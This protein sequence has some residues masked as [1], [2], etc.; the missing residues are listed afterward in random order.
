MS[1]RVLV[2]PEDPTNNGYILKPL[3][4]M[5]LAEAGRPSATV[6]VLTNPRLRGY[7]HA[8]RA[9]REELAVRYRHMDLWLFFPDAD[10]AKADAMRDL[11]E[12]LES[13]GITLL[14]C[15]AE[16]EVEIYATVAY[17]NELDIPWQEAR[18][19]GSFK[20]DV[21]PPLLE[22]HG[23]HRRPGGGRSQMTI[24]SLASRQSFFSRCPEVANLRDRIKQWRQLQALQA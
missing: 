2:I 23:D 4:K 10:R 12:S 19:H 9:I 8:V 21:F 24:A 11:E 15:P 7:D 6:N 20:E 14:C 16:P 13:E 1:T 5:V 22:A 3:T 17:R 18:R